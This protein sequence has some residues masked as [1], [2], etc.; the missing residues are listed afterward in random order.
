MRLEEEKS[1]RGEV[2]RGRKNRCGLA[3]WFGRLI[4]FLQLTF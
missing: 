3:W 2:K 4:F 1:E